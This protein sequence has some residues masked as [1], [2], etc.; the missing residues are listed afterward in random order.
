MK[1]RGLSSISSNLC[2][3]RVHFRTSILIVILHV[4][5]IVELLCI[6]HTRSR[7]QMLHQVLRN[8]LK[9][10]ACSGSIIAWNEPWLLLHLKLNLIG[11]DDVF[12][13]LLLEL[14]ELLKGLNCLKSAVDF[15]FDEA[16]FM[17]AFDVFLHGLHI[18]VCLPQLMYLLLQIMKLSH[19]LCNSFSLRLFV[20]L[21]FEDL[22][23]AAP[24][25]GSSLHQIVALSV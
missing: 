11:C 9:L 17:K 22:L 5:L 4:C 3:F 13:L 15:L 18:L 10:L 24:P 6:L 21:G 20:P 23:L 19:F 14:L 8:A 16:L 2:V 12:L 7:S 25:E 1:I